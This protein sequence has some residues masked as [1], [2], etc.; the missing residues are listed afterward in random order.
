MPSPGDLMMSPLF[1]LPV[2]FH[3]HL[4]T[5]IPYPFSIGPNASSSKTL[6]QQATL[7]LNSGHYS[8]GKYLHRK[9]SQGVWL[10]EGRGPRAKE[11][12]DDQT[13][14]HKT[15]YM[16][17]RRGHWLSLSIINKLILRIEYELKEEFYHLLYNPGTK[18]QLEVRLFPGMIL[19]CA[20]CHIIKSALWF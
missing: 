12:Q 4:R 1:L 2:S 3:F 11:R 17:R 13:T 14:Y 16:N 10:G 20:C 5:N 15:I 7:I 19:Q 18:T 8:H 9:L 6:P